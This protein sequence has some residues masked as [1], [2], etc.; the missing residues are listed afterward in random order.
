MTKF[1]ETLNNGE[2]PDLNLHNNH[3]FDYCAFPGNL[4]TPPTPP[5]LLLSLAGDGI[6]D[7]GLG[8]FRE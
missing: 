3:T 1:L 7:D 5:N 6:Q 2:D 8:H 4:H